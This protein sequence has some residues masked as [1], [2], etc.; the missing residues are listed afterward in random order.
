V[1]ARVTL[2]LIGFVPLSR[3]VHA[4]LPAPARPELLA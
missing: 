1:G 2:A 3:L 4:C